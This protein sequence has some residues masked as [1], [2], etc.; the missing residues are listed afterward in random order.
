M[1]ERFM[2]T[3]LTPSVLAA[4]EHYYGRRASIGSVA[5]RDP[6]TEEERTFIEAR[7]SFYMATI[8]ESGWPYIQRPKLTLQVPLGDRFRLSA[9]VNQSAACGL[10]GCVG[11]L[12]RIGADV[13][14]PA[15][16]A[17]I[18]G[19]AFIERAMRFLGKSTSVTVTMTFCCTLTTSAGSLR[20]FQNLVLL[21][22]IL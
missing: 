10:T 18:V 19:A 1:A 9:S 17:P 13:V 21:G 11:G 2:K 8:T 20:L 4:Q 3:V 15:G 16:S 5:E 22:I 7:D 6:L 14:L 12:T